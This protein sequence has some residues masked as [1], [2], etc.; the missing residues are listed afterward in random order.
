[1]VYEER[2]SPNKKI[3]WQGVIRVVI[4]NVASVYMKLIMTTWQKLE[5]VAM[6][7]FVDYG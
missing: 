1:V 5:M 4:N 2:G 6:Q 3:I 7:I